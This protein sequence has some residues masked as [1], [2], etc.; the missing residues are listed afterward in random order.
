M[1][2]TARIASA[3]ALRSE[4]VWRVE[5]TLWLGQIEESGRR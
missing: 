1:S 3:K 2:Q 4:C 5:G